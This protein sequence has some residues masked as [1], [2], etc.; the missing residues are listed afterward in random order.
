M[1]QAMRILGHLLLAEPRRQ[2]GAP[3]T[4]NYLAPIN[5]ACNR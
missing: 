3:F 4:F 1:I 5:L 2:C